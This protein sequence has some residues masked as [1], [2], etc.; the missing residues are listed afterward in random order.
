MD[1]SELFISNDDGC[2]LLIEPLEDEKVYVQIS[3]YANGAFYHLNKEEAKQIVEHLTKV[4][5]L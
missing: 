3:Y 1:D 2:D 4:F 5:E